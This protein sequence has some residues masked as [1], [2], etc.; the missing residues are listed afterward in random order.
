M[1][2]T[3]E[4]TPQAYRQS[5]LDLFAEE[6]APDLKGKSPDVIAVDGGTILQLHPL[7]HT[8]ACIA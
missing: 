5:D 3:V 4:Y 8:H 1:R 6:F 2:F 7:T